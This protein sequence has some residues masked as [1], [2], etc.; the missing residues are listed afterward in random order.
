[1]KLIDFL[2][3]EEAFKFRLANAE[4]LLS[5]VKGAR[6]RVG[7]MALSGHRW[8]TRLRPQQSVGQSNT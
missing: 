1:M 3:G 4:T 8:L 7:H 2:R 5:T 6:T